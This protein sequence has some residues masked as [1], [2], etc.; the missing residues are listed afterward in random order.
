MQYSLALKAQG[1]RKAALDHVSARR[2]KPVNL[3]GFPVEKSRRGQFP[4]L[5]FSS[6]RAAP[7]GDRVG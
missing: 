2:A 7:K 5:V 4:M 6:S 1:N 3:T